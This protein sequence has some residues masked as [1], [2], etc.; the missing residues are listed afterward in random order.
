MKLR[1]LRSDSLKT[2]KRRM[3]VLK[4]AYV[5]PVMGVELFMANAAVSTCTVEGGI[6][7]N[8]DCMYGP[9]VDTATVINDTIATGCNTKIGYADGIS[10]ARDYS[11]RGSHSNNNPDR[12]TWSGDGRGSAYL[13]VTY[14]GAEGILYTDGSSN[15][16]ATVWSIEDGYVKHSRDRGGTHHM[17]APVVDSRSVNASW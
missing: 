17:V 6:S 1:D 5:R 7:Y 10:T 15:T 4:K 13:E 11:S 16:D 9:N 3:V 8:F 2:N 12:A 14:S